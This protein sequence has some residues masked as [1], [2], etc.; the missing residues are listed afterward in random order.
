VRETI[1]MRILL[2]GL[3]AL[4]NAVPLQG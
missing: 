1:I 4:L 3:V 2:F